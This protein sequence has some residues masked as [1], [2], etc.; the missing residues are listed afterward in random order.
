VRDLDAS[1]H[2]TVRNLLTHT[3]GWTGDFDRPCGRGEDALARFVDACRDAQQLLPTGTRFSYCNSGF[4]VAGRVIEVASSMSF[5]AAVTDLVFAP[6]GLGESF[7]LADDVMTR[8]FA[9]GHYVDATGMRVAEPWHVPRHAAPAGGVVSSVRD[10]VR[11]ARFHLGTGSV[12]GTGAVLS[13]KS[14]ADM[15]TGAVSTGGAPGSAVG[16][17]WLI[18]RVGGHPAYYHGGTTNGQKSAL[19]LMPEHGFAVTVLTNSNTGAELHDAIVTWALET[20]L[21]ITPPNAADLVITVE[22][23]M[24]ARFAGVY[25]S[26]TE[27]AEVLVVDGHLRAT[28]RDVGDSPELA[29]RHEYPPADLWPVSADAFIIIDGPYRGSGAHFSEGGSGGVDLMSIAG[30]VLRRLT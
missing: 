7:F 23:E 11:Y 9:V 3:S 21:G 13:A 18:R 25:T 8:R 5:E 4:S 6:L 16:L 30:R 19:L 22:P 27:R 26:E 28:Y 20:H 29:S 2:V 1:E 17:A 24:L 10:Q 12:A 15:K 14:L